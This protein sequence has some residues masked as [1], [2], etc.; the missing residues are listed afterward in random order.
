MAPAAAPL[1]LHSAVLLSYLPLRMEGPLV[2]HT[3]R[4]MSGRRLSDKLLMLTLTWSRAL[5]LQGGQELVHECRCVG[6]WNLLAFR[7][8]KYWGNLRGI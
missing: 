2:Y 3:Q 1:R 6:I 4:M 5:L 8:S 7:S